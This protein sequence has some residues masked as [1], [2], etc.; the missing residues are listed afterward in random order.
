MRVV[1]EQ[2]DAALREVVD[3]TSASCVGDCWPSPTCN[4]HRPPV[5]DPGA[6]RSFEG[7]APWRTITSLFTLVQS[8]RATNH[9]RT[10]AFRRAPLH[11]P[12]G[13]TLRVSRKCLRN[14]CEPRGPA[15]WRDNRRHRTLRRGVMAFDP[16]ATHAKGRP[17]LHLGAVSR[18][19]YPP[20]SAI[21]PRSRGN[22][23]RLVDR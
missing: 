8:C 6:V 5:C 9:T 15:P 14:S 1:G 10:R 7:P 4:A 17:P 22:G 19:T 2:A 21:D 16:L 11:V 3:V 23:H 13:R 20:R 18:S 12:R